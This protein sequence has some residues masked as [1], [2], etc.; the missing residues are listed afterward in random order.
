MFVAGVDVL[1]DG[2]LLRMGMMD[3]NA[4]WHPFSYGFGASSKEDGVSGQKEVYKN[5]GLHTTDASF[6]PVA[7]GGP[8]SL[9]IVAW[10]SCVAE[11]LINNFPNQFQK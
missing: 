9:S 3:H 6:L 7:T 1:T 4:S 8:A 11:Q 2:E 5:I 10:S